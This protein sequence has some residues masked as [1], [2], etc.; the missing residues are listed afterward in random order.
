L[1]IVYCIIFSSSTSCFIVLLQI[2]RRHCKSAEPEPFS[3]SREIY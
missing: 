2:Q 1:N 3:G